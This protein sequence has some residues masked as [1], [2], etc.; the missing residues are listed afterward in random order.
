[1]EGLFAA[2]AAIGPKD[3]VDTITEAG[4]AAMAAGKYLA[5]LSRQ[6]QETVAA[7]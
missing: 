4:N 3:I 2:G 1:M 7:Q 5:A 6:G